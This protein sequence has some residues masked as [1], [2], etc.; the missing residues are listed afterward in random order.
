MPVLVALAPPE[1]LQAAPEL[2]RLFDAANFLAACGFRFGSELLDDAAERGLEA[3][4]ELFVIRA[5]RRGGI[6][7]EWRGG[8]DAEWGGGIRAERRG[9]I[10]GA[11]NGDDRS[12]GSCGLI[13][14]GH[15]VLAWVAQEFL[16]V[17]QVARCCVFSMRGNV[18]V[19]GLTSV[20][21]R[22]AVPGDELGAV[23]PFVAMV[24][25]KAEAKHFVVARC[26]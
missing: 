11:F 6:D 5:E 7:V 23:G 16:P 22:H 17:P 4:G 8:V 15:S 24:G 14:S 18:G 26:V 19:V 25:L 9:G 1:V 13:R 10:N 12:V 2:M 3:F 20:G 21:A